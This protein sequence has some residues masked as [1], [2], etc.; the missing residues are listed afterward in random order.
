MCDE[1]APDEEG[2][3][4]QQ[5]RP[6]RERPWLTLTRWDI[7]SCTSLSWTLHAM[8]I[9][10]ILDRSKG[11]STIV[12]TFTSVHNVYCAMVAVRFLKMLI[13]NALH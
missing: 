1:H 3:R 12:I 11:L 6:F 9:T 7:G 10:R 2:E 5:A 4:G 8:L 13:V